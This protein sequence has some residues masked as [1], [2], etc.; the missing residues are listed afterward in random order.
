[1][2]SSKTILIVAALAALASAPAAHAAT[3]PAATWPPANSGCGEDGPTSSSDRPTVALTSRA[4]RLGDTGRVRAQVRGDQ[5]AATTVTITQAGGKRVGGTVAGTYTCATPA[6]AVVSLPI[7]D[8]GRKLV[9]RH[10]RLEV[11][12]T[13][14]LV[15]GSG[16]QS[17][18]R[19][20]AVIRPMP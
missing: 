16:V 7:N 1:M 20:S 3:G 2:R 8:Y 4:L 11:T 14:R 12:L 17:T 18:V 6:R 13:F 19:R 10:G 9:R 5:T 15:N